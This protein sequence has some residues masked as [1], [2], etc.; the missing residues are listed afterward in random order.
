MIMAAANLQ[1][2]ESQ[3][4]LQ[5]LNWLNDMAAYGSQGYKFAKKVAPAAGDMW[6]Q[7]DPNSFDKYAVP[8]TKAFLDAKDF[9]KANGGWAAVDNLGNQM[10]I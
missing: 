4:D 3:Q 2:L 1:N 9:G 10:G 8:G 5:N 6:R 7:V